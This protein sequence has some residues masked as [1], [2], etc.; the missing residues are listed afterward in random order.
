MAGPFRR[1]QKTGG[2]TY[3]VS[4]PKKWVEARLKKGD[5]VQIFEHGNDLV[6]TADAKP[7]GQVAVRLVFEGNLPKL[8]RQVIAYYLEGTDRFFIACQ[9]DVRASIQ[10][11]LKSRVPGLEVVEETDDGVLMQN[12]LAQTGISFHATLRRLHSLGLAMLDALYQNLNDGKNWPLDAFERESDRFFILA[13]RQLGHIQ[14]ADSDVHQHAVYYVIAIKSLEKIADHAFIF[15]KHAASISSGR[16][17]ALVRQVDAA[18]EAYVAALSALLKKDP[19][20]AEDALELIANLRPSVFSDDF[21]SYNL[22]RVLDYSSDVAEMALDM[23]SH[24]QKT[25]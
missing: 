22:Q 21:L 16:K 12:L 23:Y 8:V 10:E 6:I 18:R 25:I 13:F 19:S 24:D 17:K 4:L 9:S 1:I 20:A 14:Q 5:A 7:K 3:I 15:S 2:S 11:E